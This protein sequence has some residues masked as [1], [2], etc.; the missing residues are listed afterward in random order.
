MHDATDARIERLISLAEELSRLDHQ[1]C[2]FAGNSD[3]DAAV[4]AY[5]RG[6]RR[7]VQ[8]ELEA[9]RSQI[10]SDGG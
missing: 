7:A 10:G 3:S 2:L 5:L 8:V 4:R 1:R 9:I 6:K